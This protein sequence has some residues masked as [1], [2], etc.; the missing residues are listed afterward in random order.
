LITDSHT[1]HSSL[2][3]GVSRL[4]SVIKVLFLTAEATP[5]VKVGGLGDVSGSLPNALISLN[6]ASKSAGQKS[7]NNIDI[8]LVIPFYKKIQAQNY[9]FQELYTIKVHSKK[10]EFPAKIFYLKHKN[11]PIYFISGNLLE[12]NDAIYS[13]DAI[14]DGKKFTFFSLAS[15]EL[16]KYLNW[17]PDIIHANEWHTAITPYILK[18]T[19]SNIKTVLG[20]HNLPYLGL[21]AGKALAYFNIKPSS[22]KN[23]P[24]WARNAP[25]PLGLSAADKIVTVSPTYAKE[26]L[27]PEFGAGLDTFLISKKKHITGILNG[28][29]INYWN[30]ALD[31]HIVQNYD[32]K[33]ISLRKQNKVNLQN[34]FNLKE[35]PSV[36]LIAVISRINLQK[37]IDLLPKAIELVAKRM[38]TPWQ[39]IILGS[40]DP[41]I[42]KQL[43]EFAKHYSEQTRLIMRYD[44]ELSHHIYASADILLI[45]SRYEPCGLTQMIAMRYGCIPV[46]RATGGLKD[47]IRDFNTHKNS[48]G[49]LFKEANSLQLASTITRALEIFTYK[50]KWIDLQKRAMRKDFSWRRSARKYLNLYS[51]LVNHR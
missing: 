22:D 38:N 49:F 16:I 32:V 43:K 46:A 13:S 29:D 7:I 35:N 15:L 2:N 36:P 20:V 21:G 4:N 45:P 14:H 33:R 17:K 23:L 12:E 1:N 19:N 10:G 47:S 37:G 48:T 9:N 3:S 11:I 41:Q 6:T 24:K 51:E 31:N 18:T 50:D 8:R 39:L 28:I 27:T 30:P 40:G 26:M 5:F 42:E 44:S 25:L 34:S